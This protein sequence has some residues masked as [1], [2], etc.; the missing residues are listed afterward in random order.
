MNY[1]WGDEWS[2]KE[3]AEPLFMAG[4]SQFPVED[5]CDVEP[6]LR[7]MKDMSFGS[8]DG[9]DMPVLGVSVQARGLASHTHTQVQ[10]QHKP[11]LI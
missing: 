5:V 2:A 3:G 9:S 1:W 6:T 7:M 11:I 4:S 8:W 10:T